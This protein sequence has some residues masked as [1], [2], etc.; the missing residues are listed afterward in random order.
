MARF[1]Y[2]NGRTMITPSNMFLLNCAAHFLEMDGNGSSRHSLIDQTEKSLKGINF[3][4]WSELLEALKQCQNLLPATKSSVMLQCILDCLIERIALPSI[5]SPYTCSSDSS[6]F[7]FS[8]DT[9]IDSLKS[10]SSQLT[11]WFEDLLFLNVDLIDKLIKTMVSLKVNHATIYK[12]LFYY[13]K[14][15]CIGAATAEKRKITEVVISLLSLLDRSSL[16]CKG[17]F[18]IYRVALGLRISKFYKN[19]L[20]SLMGSQL[21]QATIDYLLAPSPHKR[22]YFYDVNLVLRLVQAFLLEGGSLS[23]TSR[24][25]KVTKL[26]DSYLVEVA[27][28]SHLKPSKFTALVLLLPDYAR[29]S[30]DRVYRAMDLFLEVHAGLCEEEKRSVCCALNHEKLS[31]EVLKDLSRNSKFPSQT[32]QM[33][34]I[35]Q[36]SMI[37]CSLPDTHRLLTFCD[38]LFCSNTKENLGKE[39]SETKKLRADLQG[40]HWK[41]MGL[42]KVCGTM[43]TEMANIMRSRL[44]ILG[45]ARSVPKLCS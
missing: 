36:Q 18:E 8:C 16:S 43:Q 13:H 33:A 19:N 38:S 2:D 32:V 21:D 45:N 35:T 11:W 34:L 20:E 10:S 25:K 17:L 44:S 5:A 40:M 12:F 28:D 22:A 7:Q 27:P 6:S 39:D 37:K 30:Y 3:W 42:E 9:S 15:R 14:S 4:T 1:C 31:E 23:F 29:A 41:M 26:L 24:L